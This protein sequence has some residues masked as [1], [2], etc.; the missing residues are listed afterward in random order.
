MFYFAPAEAVVYNYARDAGLLPPNYRDRASGETAIKKI[1]EANRVAIQ[2][3][4]HKPFEVEKLNT[5]GGALIRHIVNTTGLD[6]LTV[7]NFMRALQGVAYSGKLDYKVYD[8]KSPHVTST[9]PGL[10]DAASAITKPLGDYVIT[11]TNKVLFVG[12]GLGA[13]AIYLRSK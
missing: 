12:L 4:K 2:S 8:P 11:L 7:T 1:L 3:G 9:I 10:D 5:T 13:L 6:F